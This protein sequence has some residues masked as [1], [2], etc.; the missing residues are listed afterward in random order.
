MKTCSLR[1]VQ[2][3]SYD[4]GLF[5]RDEPEARHG[6]KQCGNCCLCTPKYDVKRRGQS[7]VQFGASQRHQFVN[8]YQAILNCPAVSFF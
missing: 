5:C 1:N 4:E 8:K 6:M 2:T 3:R 7:S